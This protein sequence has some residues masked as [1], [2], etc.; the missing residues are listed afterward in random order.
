MCLIHYPKSAADFEKLL[1]D[2]KI[3]NA[4]SNS[5]TY[6]PVIPQKVWP[7]ISAMPNFSTDFEPHTIIEFHIYGFILPA[8]KAILGKNVAK[9]LQNSYQYEKSVMMFSKTSK[10]K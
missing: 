8:L 1:P 4:V 10:L 2:T 7:E 3:F 9:M 6:V 5:P